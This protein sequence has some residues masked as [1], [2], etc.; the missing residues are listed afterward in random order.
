MLGNIRAA[1]I[2]ASAIPIS[3]MF[4]F[5]GMEKLGITANIMSLGAIDFGMIVDGAIVMVENI[6]HKKAQG[7]KLSIIQVT[8]ESLR[9]MAKPIGFGILIITIVYVPILSLEGIEYK[10][11]SPMVF[12]V[13]FALLGSLITALILVPSLCI[14]FLKNN[15]QD[16]PNK[17]LEKI[18]EYYLIKLETA[19]KTPRKIIKWSVISFV[20]SCFLLMN[21]GTEFV[22][23][24]DEGDIIIEVRNLTSISVAG[25]V[26]ASTRAEQA[27]LGIP[28]IKTIVT[29]TGRPDLGTDPMGVYASDMFVHLKP[30]Q[31]W[32]FGM[33]KNKLISEMK[34]KLEEKTIGAKF[35]FTQ[36]IAMRVDE[37]VSGVRSDLAIKIFGSDLD[38][39]VKKANEI[40]KIMSKIPGQTD[41]QV[42]KLVG[43]KQVLIKPDRM[44]MS[45]YG[46]DIKDIR[47]AINTALMGTEISEIIDNQVRFSLKVKLE[48]MPTIDTIENLLIETNSG[49]KIPLGQIAKMEIADGVELINRERGRRRIIVQMNVE[50]RDMGSFVKEAKQAINKE[51]KLDQGYQIEW[52]GQFQNQER[53]MKRLLIVVPISILIIFGLLVLSLN[54]LSE[55]SIVLLNVPLALIG[56]VLALFLRGMY[57]S[58]PAVIGFIALFGVAVLNGLVLI[59]TFNKLKSEITNL[60]DLIL[61]GAGSRLRPVLMTAL[62]AILGF[63]PMAISHGAG[64]EVQKPLA[65]VVIGGL[66][67]ST[68]LTLLC[69]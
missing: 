53:A 39:L 42:E 4:S 6:L 49:V 51:V 45:L 50:H 61:Q 40:E 32:R 64:A 31:Q 57:I 27:L 38:V 29:K 37:L 9:E 3:L 28:E 59:S 22:P 63:L 66:L 36:P 34:K 21:L 65:T 24:L 62:V 30:K 46:V 13:C 10:M 54:S 25:A 35:N 55:A 67:S 58:V 41:L 12:T 43:S 20:I 14:I 18:K 69:F 47:I 68:F 23:K 48:D 19:L 56:G 5:I 26:K 17:W 33:D 7:E 44:L 8:N 1:L 2:A 60:D 11:F 15:F 16:K 52:G